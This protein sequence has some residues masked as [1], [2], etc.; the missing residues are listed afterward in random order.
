MLSLVCVAA[1]QRLFQPAAPAGFLQPGQRPAFAVDQAPVV[2]V[3][4]MRSGPAEASPSV[5]MLGV[6][7]MVGV[8]GVAAYALRPQ[9]RAGSVTMQED[10][11]LVDALNKPNWNDPR[12]GNPFE[13]T[14]PRAAVE[15]YQ[16]R[17]IS[18]A[19]VP[20][21]QY[22]EVDDEPWHSTSRQT[23]QVSRTQLTEGF[24]TSLPFIA[25]EDALA[26]GLSKATKKDE[27]KKLM[28]EALKSGA[29]PGCPIIGAGEK[30]L[31]AFEE[32]SEEE[33]LKAR[34]K[35]PKA[36]GAQGAG[37]DGMKRP[38]GAVHSTAGFT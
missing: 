28:D 34:P 38:L 7:G 20:K 12:E 15:A 37:W 16:P 26:V 30:L 24:Q 3:V 19:T 29:R 18:D 8:M 10:P 33:A 22:I 5:S 31:K 6:I 1:A 11:G 27:V 21:K 36:A 17:G 25:A 9:S 35:A 2:D 13:D 32:K 4:P 14:G 23:V